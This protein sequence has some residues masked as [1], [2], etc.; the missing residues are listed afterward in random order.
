MPVKKIQK[1]DMVVHACNSGTQE[2]DAGGLRVEGHQKY[3]I[4]K[5]FATVCPFPSVL[6]SGRYLSA[7]HSYGCSISGKVVM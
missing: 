2:A 7:I 6:G 4:K 3:K 1:L 5:I